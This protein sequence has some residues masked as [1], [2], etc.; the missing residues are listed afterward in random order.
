MPK[1]K[2]YSKKGRGKKSYSS[3]KY[4]YNV[5]RV[6]R[7][8]NVKPRSAMQNVTYYNSFRCQPKVNTSADPESRQQNFNIVVGLNSLWPFATN[9]NQNASVNG[10]VCTPNEEINEYVTAPTPPATHVDDNTTVMPNVV[11]G[12]G[13]FNQYSKCCVVGTKVTLTATP[14]KNNTDIQMGYLYAIKHS[15]PATG[16]STTSTITDINKMPYV[17]L[18]KLAGPDAPTSGFQS[19]EKVGAKLIITHSPKKFNNVADVRDNQAL[20]NS[21]GTN[22]VATRPGEGDYLTIGVIPSLNKMDEQVTDF[23]LQMRI[24]QR[25]LWTEPRESLVGASAGQGNYSFPWS[26]LMYS[27]NL[28]NRAYAY[29][30]HMHGRNLLSY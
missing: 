25:L 2:S 12:A 1:G 4:R 26:A 19:G 27:A 7:H 10:Q 28:F 14:I 24:E 20:F 15:Q 3:S 29:N 30:K 11:D 22:G 17:K 16:L 6:N 23:C 13:L 5:A 8:L 21:T 18:A 9:W